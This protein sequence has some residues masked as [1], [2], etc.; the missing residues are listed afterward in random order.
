MGGLNNFDVEG[1]S[2]SRRRR[3][4]DDYFNGDDGT[5]IDKFTIDDNTNM[6]GFNKG[7]FG[8]ANVL[9]Q[10]RG[11]VSSNS[12]TQLIQWQ[13]ESLRNVRREIW[14][15]ASNASAP[16]SSSSSSSSMSSTAVASNES[17]GWGVEGP[18]TKNNGDDT[19]RMTPLVDILQ[20]RAT[21]RTS[22]RRDTTNTSSSSNGKV[23]NG[24]GNYNNNNNNK[25]DQTTITAA[26]KTIENDM[27]I[28]DVLASLQPQLSGTEVGL[29]LGAI[30]VSGVGPIFF[31]GT[32]VTEVLAPAAAACE[33]VYIIAHYDILSSRDLSR[34]IF[35]AQC[36][37]T[38]HCTDLFTRMPHICYIIH[39]YHPS[40]VIL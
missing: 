30:V 22:S 4:D 19:N 16:V 10:R 15:R 25:Q 29:L 24:K 5:N 18:V 34:C 6:D 26:L 39:T 23:N 13:R 14:D 37:L 35:I 31:P 7:A 40:V 38:N 8:I 1:S 3:S 33:C 11:G 21:A 32:S 12:R 9:S 2:S 27:A 36:I 20:Q 17:G 28:L